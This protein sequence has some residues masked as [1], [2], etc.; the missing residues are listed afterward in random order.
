MKIYFTKKL[1]EAMEML[2]KNGA[3]LTVGDNNTTNTMTISWGQIGY[4]WNKPVFTA[5][6]R[7]SRYTHSLLEKTNNFTISIPFHE[8]F[9]DE[10]AYCGSH[11]GSN[12]DKIKNCNLSLNESKIIKSPCIAGCNLFFECKVLYK[13][14]L[15]LSNLDQEIVNKFY[16]DNDIHTLFYGEIL[17]TSFYE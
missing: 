3:F 2:H 15:D 10:L 13:T 17:R 5:L 9:K 6:V 12:E 4:Q 1:D 16:A 7:K 14:D 8:S 11:S